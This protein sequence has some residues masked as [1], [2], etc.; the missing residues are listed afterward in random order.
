MI[1]PGIE[2]QSPGP[3]VN[4]VNFYPLTHGLKGKNLQKKKMKIEITFMHNVFGL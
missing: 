4:S 3:S 2:P 1:R